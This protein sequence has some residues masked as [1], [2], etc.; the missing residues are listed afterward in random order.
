MQAIFIAIAI[1][2][3]LVIVEY[4]TRSTPAPLRWSAIGVGVLILLAWLAFMAGLV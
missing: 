2:I 3:G 1:A 4:V